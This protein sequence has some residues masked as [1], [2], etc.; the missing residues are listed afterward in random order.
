MD[1]SDA[2]KDFI[3]ALLHLQDQAKRNEATITVVELSSWGDGLSLLTAL[4]A[5][6]L[7]LHQP[8]SGLEPRRDNGW[9]FIQL[10]GIHIRWPARR[11]THD[12]YI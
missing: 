8:L 6:P 5:S 11:L 10:V 1:R 7:A 4:R 12:T 2:L 9:W 3:E